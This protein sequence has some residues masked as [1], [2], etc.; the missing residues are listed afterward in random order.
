MHTFN[1][2]YQPKVN[3]NNI[4]SIEALLRPNNVIDIEHYVRNHKKPIELDLKVVNRVIYDIVKYKLT[5]PISINISYFSFI[6]DYFVDYCIKKL[7]NLNVYLELTEINEIKDINKLCSNIE[8]IRNAKI[9]ISL[10]DF[11]KDF[12]KSYLLTGIKFDQIKFDKSLIDNI[13]NSFFHYKR[14]FFLTRKI[15]KIGINNIVYEGV[16]RK[17]QEKLIKSFNPYPTIQGYLYYKPMPIES[18]IT[19]LSTP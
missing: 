15:N 5:I 11:G 10:D 17:K 2:A 19:I 4:I 12:S 18:I 1:L 13:D 3:D 16:E 6:D 14:L 9:L 8:K 7:Q